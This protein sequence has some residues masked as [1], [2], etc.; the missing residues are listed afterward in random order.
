MAIDEQ[1]FS[2]LPG[3]LLS[4]KSKSNGPKGKVPKEACLVLQ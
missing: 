2:P 3:M 1:K 4:L